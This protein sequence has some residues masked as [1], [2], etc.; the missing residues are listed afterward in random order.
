MGFI[1]MAPILPYF[2]WQGTYSLTI[3]TI[4]T[5]IFFKIK[6]KKFHFLLFFLILGTSFITAFYWSDLRYIFSS[7]FLLYSIFYVQLL[8]KESLDKAIN[9]ATTFLLTVT[10]LAIVGFMLAFIGYE[11]IYSFN[12]LDERVNYLYFTTFTNSIKQNFIRPSGIYDE[13]GAL[14]FYICILAYLRSHLNKN[15]KVTWLMLMLGFVTF[16]VAH[17]IYVIFHV[18]SEKFSIKNTVHIFFIIVITV[19]FFYF[20]G[21]H[22]FFQ[23][24]LFDRFSYSDDSESFKGDNRSILLENA[25]NYLVTNPSSILYGADPTCRFDMNTCVAKIGHIADN[26]LSPL[27]ITGVFISWPYYLMLGFLITTI[28]QGRKYIN[29]IGIV[30]IF[31]QRP[32]ILDITGAMAASLIAYVIYNNLFASTHY[33]KKPT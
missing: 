4:I 28:S 9:I 33:I 29:S 22:D 23:T 2:G 32:G 18:L 20:L 7:I 31:F 5:I 12:N 1:Y 10:V 25:A 21:I 24:E 6:I 15:S 13:P 30:L 14:S 27:V 26:P 3:I 8:S 17:L 11:P 19:L 16:S